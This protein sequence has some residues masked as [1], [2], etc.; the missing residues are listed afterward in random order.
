MFE[1]IVRRFLYHPTPIPR[2]RPPPRWVGAAEE[3][4][5]RPDRGDADGG[6]GA[7]SGDEIHGLYWPPPERAGVTRPTFLFLHGNAQ[8][9]FEWAMVRD[10]LAAADAGMLLI[11]YPGYGKSR[12]VPTES[13]LYAAGRAALRWLVEERETPL[14]DIVIFGK[15]LGGGVAT[16]LCT[17]NVV[18]G[19]I[20]ES[21]FSSVPDVAQ[22][23]IPFMPTSLVFTGERYPSSERMARITS[24]VLVIHGDRDALI[25]VRQ[26]KELYERANQPK[27][28]YVVTG[29][30][31]ND[32]AAVAGTA[33]GDKIRAWL[34][35]L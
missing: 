6:S 33:Y 2:D 13:S 20:L 26:G 19:L 4:W 7:N 16:E 28:L 10:D 24:P 30:G 22:R 3:V 14:A 1:L 31:H 35:S 11:D 17:D 29:A 5:L 27:E 9:V 25:P 8:T 18:S 23:V 34:D 15:S 21:T 12:G 32:V